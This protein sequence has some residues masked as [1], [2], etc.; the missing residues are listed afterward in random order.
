MQV[1][2]IFFFV[3]ACACCH[4]A[5]GQNRLYLSGGVEL[6]GLNYNYKFEN[7]KNVLRRGSY[8]YGASNTEGLCLGV[9]VSAFK[10]ISK[11]FGLGAGVQSTELDLVIRDA[12]FQ[13]R[14]GSQTVKNSDVLHGIFADAGNFDFAYWYHS[15]F[16]SGYFTIP[17]PGSVHPYFGA[18]ASFNSFSTRETTKRCNYVDAATSEHLDVIARYKKNYFGEFI[19][20]G[21]LFNYSDYFPKRSLNAGTGLFIGLKYYVAGKI[22]SGDYQNSLNGSIQYADHVTASGSYLALSVRFGPA[23]LKR[24]SVHLKTSHPSVH[25]SHQRKKKQNALP[26]KKT[27]PTSKGW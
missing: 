25:K 24:K 27:L 2:K 13:A 26:A 1:K 11:Y 22:I 19:E 5:I 4:Y 16:F 7:D 10:Q 21:F 12:N 3:L 14:T 23:F 6:S 18:G 20:A 15:V 9:N 17:S 8:I